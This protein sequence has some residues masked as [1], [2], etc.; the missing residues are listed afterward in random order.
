ML[1]PCYVVSCNFNTHRKPS[2]LLDQGADPISTYILLQTKAKRYSCSSPGSSALPASEG[3]KTSS[4]HDQHKRRFEEAVKNS[5]YT[6]PA[7]CTE[8]LLA[9]GWPRGLD[10]DPD[11][12]N[13]G[14]P[15]CPT[16]QSKRVC[17]S[18][19][20][21][22]FAADAQGVVALEAGVSALRSQLPSRLK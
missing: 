5:A 16:G 22:I 10:V 9:H 14:T 2:F 21:P 13:T 1:Q 18:L 19:V 15:A 17:Q 20:I 6:V 11:D 8:W 3:F 7:G 4:S 12:H